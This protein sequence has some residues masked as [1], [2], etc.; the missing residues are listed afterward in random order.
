MNIADI[1]EVLSCYEHNKHWT[2]LFT[3]EP[4]DVQDLRHFYQ[5]AIA[6]GE[7]HL[8]MYQ[9]FD[10][11][12]ST[13]VPNFS[14]WVKPSEDISVLQLL[15]HHMG[16]NKVEALFDM[17]QRGPVEFDEFKRVIGGAE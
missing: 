12:Q 3:G 11:Y 4:E 1:Q 9:L 14:E 7:S 10:L 16:R 8:D 13:F 17:Q 15:A 5:R 6:S 2:V